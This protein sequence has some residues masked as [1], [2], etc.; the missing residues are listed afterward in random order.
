MTRLALLGLLAAT[1]G[2]A[3]DPPAKVKPTKPPTK[4][5]EKPRTEAAAAPAGNLKVLPGFK[6]ELIYTVPKDTQGSWVCL[7]H[8]PKGRLIASDQYGALYRVTTGATA[9]DTK[10]EKLPVELGMAQGLLWAFDHLYVVV[11]A[12]G[13][14]AGLYKVAFAGDTP[15]KVTKL[16]GF[17]GA[18]GEHGCH[19]VMLHPDGK[20]LTLVCGNQTKMTDIATS[21]VPKLW[22]DDHLLPRVPDGNGFMKGVL[23]PGGYIFNC[24]PE[25]KEAELVS[26]GFRNE[27][28]AAYNRDGEL[29]TFDADMEWDFNTPWYRPTRVCH[30]TSG[31]EWGWRNGAGKYPAYYPDNLPPVVNIGPGSPTGVSFGYGAKFPKKYQDAFFICDW[32]Y[33]KLYAVHLKPKG[34][35]YEAETVEEFIS[36][37]PLPL[38]DLV[39]NPKD[40]AM[41]FAVGGRKTQSG[42]YRVTYVGGEPA[43][44]STTKPGELGVVIGGPPSQDEI[45]AIAGQR[46]RR[47][48]EAFHGKHDPKAVAAAWP[49]LS[50]PDRFLRFAARTAVESQP[51]VG[52]QDKALTETN[53]QAAIE[54]ILALMRAAAPCPE[55][56][57]D[58]KPQPELRAKVLAALGRLDFAKLTE[59]QKLDLAR[60]Y[61]VALHRLGK[62]DNGERDALLVKL[63]GRFPTGN[64]YLDGELLNVL[65]FLQSPTAATKGLKLL[66]DAPTQ[67]EQL[68]YVRALRV[69]TA[70]WTP[71]LRADY[72]KWFLKAASYK[73]GNSFAK[74]LTLIKT[75]AVA[76]LPESDKV[77]LKPILEATP[78]TTK[79]AA[80]PPRAFVKK[81]A[82]DDLHAAVT[83][84]LAGGR[85]YDK[86]RR[87]FAATNCF[88]CHRYDNEGGSSGPD[89]SGIA[90]RFSPKDLLESILDPSKEVSDQYQAV[91][92]ETVDGRKVVGRIVN[93]NAD[94]V[95]VLTD[96]LDPNGM[97]KLNRNNIE[98]MTP[99]KLSLMPAG[100]LDT[101]TAPEAADLMAYLLSRGDRGAAVF[102]K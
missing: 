51:V 61:E 1:I 75:D 4:P 82:I 42:L 69:L 38:T 28:D 43:K 32:S 11:N 67:E 88:G 36:G 10:V 90:G 83:P 14:K 12:G 48:L 22:G 9:A 71:E 99:S 29:F 41:Y 59:S 21:R 72:F 2:L 85:D 68:E 8:D 6:A 52:W 96:L 84:L 60:V 89:L 65:V 30:V 15:G 100:L 44:A 37:T 94:G 74:F 98:R 46:T 56:V 24:D 34:A 97:T 102:K 20:R 63:D 101:L 66:A 57:K 7:C 91:E 40:G 13:D 62:P 49:H 64:R 53:P 55:H 87:L 50:S 80:A 73:G 23:A 45:D 78:A 47:Q 35:S 76:L 26:V 39:V 93:L 81:W 3:Q 77:A 17:V 92:I 5:P 31:S 25:G 27:Y 58:A 54:A 19:A 79:V 95:D 70:G 33:G 16:R 18:G 86:G